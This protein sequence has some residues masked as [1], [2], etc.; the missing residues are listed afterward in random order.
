MKKTY[1]IDNKSEIGKRVD[2]FLTMKLS[3]YSRSYIKELIKTGNL[4]VNK[5]VS[6]SFNYRLNLGDQ[7]EIEVKDDLKEHTNQI[8]PISRKIDVVFEDENLIVVNKEEGL[9]SH[10]TNKDDKISLLNA[11]YHHIYGTNLD[12][13]L[14]IMHRLDKTTSGC[15]VFSKNAKYTYLLT[16][17]FENKTIEKHYV[18]VV[19]G[20]FLS[21]YGEELMIKK[22]IGYNKADFKQVI[23]PEGDYAETIVR[24]SD[25]NTK[26]RLTMLD[27]NIVTGRKHQIRLH[28]SDAGFPVLGDQKYGGSEFDRIMLHAKKLII[29][30]LEGYKSDIVCDS[31]LP[32][33]FFDLLNDDAV[34]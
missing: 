15:V 28:L 13:Y 17:L 9:N 12:G 20:D 24:V 4:T 25:Y 8:I 11:V 14:R 33:E 5:E 10:P 19:T 23:D 7:I 27:I 18:A 32:K 22:H 26:K 6:T 31:E 3:Q 29:S 16:R 30:D 34:N 2:I 1:K 21:K